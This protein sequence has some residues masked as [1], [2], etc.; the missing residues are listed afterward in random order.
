LKRKARNVLDTRGEDFCNNLIQIS[1][2]ADPRDPFV[3]PS[4]DVIGDNDIMNQ[5]DAAKA[6]LKTLGDRCPKDQE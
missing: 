6:A 4:T 1:E 3:G 2:Q 5:I